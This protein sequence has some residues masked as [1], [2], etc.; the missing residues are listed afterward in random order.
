[1]RVERPAIVRCPIVRIVAVQAASARAAGDARRARQ[2]RHHQ[3]HCCG[4]HEHHQHALLQNTFHSHLLECLV[5]KSVAGLAVLRA[6][7][8]RYPWETWGDQLPYTMCNYGANL[9]CWKDRKETARPRKKA[10]L[11]VHCFAAR[12]RCASE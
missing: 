9:S 2:W 3:C 6:N 1:D 12:L 10:V 4:Q 5:L 7:G 11:Y 8:Y